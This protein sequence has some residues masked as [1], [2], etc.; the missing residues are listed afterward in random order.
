V[1][2]GATR[3]KPQQRRQRP[4][5]LLAAPPGPGSVGFVDE[6]TATARNVGTT[7][8]IDC[9]LGTAVLGWAYN[10]GFPRRRA[11]IALTV[12]G[13]IA[14]TT[15]ANG[16]RQELVG[17]DGG[18]GFSGFICRI[19]PEKFTPGAAVRILADGIELGAPLILGPAQIDGAAELGAG[20]VA[21]GWVRERV[22]APTRAVLDMI[23]DGRPVRTITADRLRPEL[24]HNRIDDGCF[25]FAEA[26]PDSCLDG[27][28]HR[29]EFR[30]R[31]SGLVVPPGAARF[32]ASF[33]GQLE[34]LDQNGGS[35][36]V[37]CREAP[38]RPVR[39]DVIVN[40]VRVDVVAD[41]LR[42]DVGARHGARN[43]GFE[44]GIPDTVSRHRELFVEI[45]AAGTAN[46][47]IPGPF[48]FTPISRVIEQVEE[49]AVR[50]AQ[51]AAPGQGYSALREAIVPAILAG[52]RA[53]GQ[54]GGLP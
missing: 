19:P 38:D 16:L 26:V 30:H 36:W 3:G 34:R 20:A 50:A 11:T 13:Q 43:C 42:D 28:E 7:G 45:C 10:P 4:P 25:G 33:T 8:A 51:D 29:I 17:V 32:R 2:S 37:F 23:V 47:A 27:D 53:H 46:R 48:T 52:L 22:L 35:G 54:R 40:N 39:L 31:A 21:A 24:E 15:V 6:S 14:A 5:R 44:F 1:R 49:I 12:D 9:L 18:D 41:R